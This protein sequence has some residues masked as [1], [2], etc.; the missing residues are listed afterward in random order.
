M[1]QAEF[2]KQLLEQISKPEFIYAFIAV[3][4]VRII[5]WLFLA[6]T[7]KKALLLVSKENQCIKPNQVFGV[8]IPIF[9]IYWNF[10]VA[11]RLRDSLIN[12]FYDRKI[13]VDESPTFKKGSLYSWIYLATN[14]PLPPFISVVTVI[15]HFVT[16]I[17]YWVD[18]NNYKRILEQHNTFKDQEELEKTHE[19]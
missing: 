19:D 8:A 9:N 5:I 10:E 13:A 17:N 6:Y 3:Q 4:L 7:M 16:M 15:F 11:K 2:Q 14:I 12:E 18:I 1:D